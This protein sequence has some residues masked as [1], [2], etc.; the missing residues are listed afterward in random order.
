MSDHDSWVPAESGEPTEPRDVVQS[1]L[2]PDAAPA[3]P[4][5]LRRFGVPLGL[6]GAGAVIGAVLAATLTA[7]AAPSPTPPPSTANPPAGPCPGGPGHPGHHG[8]LAPDQT[9]TV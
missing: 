4:S 1:R 3:R 9:G 2:D 5:R 7:G 6:L 8:F